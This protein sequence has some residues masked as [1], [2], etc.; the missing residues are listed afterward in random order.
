MGCRRH[1]SPASPEVIDERGAQRPSFCRI[2]A[3]ADFVEQ[4][5]GRQF[6]R[7]LHGHDVRDVSRKRRQA[8]GDRLL[9]ADV[10]EHGLQHR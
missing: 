8:V 10:R 9:V 6:E 1:E 4:H 7:V 2:R 3:C 5:Q